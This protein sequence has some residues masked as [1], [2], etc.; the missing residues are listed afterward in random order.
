MLLFVLRLSFNPVVEILNLSVDLLIGV[1]GVDLH[2]DGMQKFERGRIGADQD[3]RPDSHRERVGDE[4]FGE[5]GIAQAIVALVCDHADDLQPRVGV[6]GGG[7]E[8]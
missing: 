4:D 2:S 7:D 3:L 6:L 1:D 8:G 5:D